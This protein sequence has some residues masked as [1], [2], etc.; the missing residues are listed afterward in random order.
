MCIL[1][2]NYFVMLLITFLKHECNGISSLNHRNL[3]GIIMHELSVD[4]EQNCFR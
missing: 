3:C 2:V 4:E 1:K